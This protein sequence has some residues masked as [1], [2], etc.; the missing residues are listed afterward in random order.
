MEI[1]NDIY[2]TLKSMVPSIKA[3]IVILAVLIVVRIILNRKYR[4]S[5][6]LKFRRQIVTL[7][8]LFV[9]M[10]AIIL[11]L[12]LSDSERGQLLSLIGILLSAAIALSSTTILGNLIAGFMLRAIR[13]FRAGD[14]IRVGDYFGRVSDRG[15]FHIE[16]QT[17]DRDLTTF[18]NMY[19]VTNPVTVSRSSGTVI[20]ATV[21]LGY[22]VPRK[23]A[24]GLLARAAED[25]AL[26]EPFVHVIELGDFSVTYRVAGLLK[27]V[28]QLISA[29]SKLRELM[30][31][32]LHEAGIEIVSPTFMNQRPLKDGQVFIPQ[33]EHHDTAD[34]EKSY[35]ELPEEVVFDKAEEAESTE[36]LKERYKNLGEEL[37]TLKESLG[38][39]GAEEKDSLKK[40]IE[41]I[42]NRRDRLA[43]IVERR[44]EDKNKD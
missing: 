16:V 24:Q 10:L 3:L 6:D 42:K 19:L 40:R 23:K 34:P 38:K 7:L 37:E 29:R 8:I 39:A 1:L 9:G 22:E 12:P 44:R 5:L 18:P 43:D 27:E 13:H 33:R 11:V 26:V 28:K 25:A 41:S 36:K 21:S 35:S 4:G 20:S 17:E 15:L 2:S 14:F 30:L 32:R 31:D